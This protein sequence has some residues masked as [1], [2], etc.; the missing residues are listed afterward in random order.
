MKKKVDI[1][2]VLMIAAMLTAGPLMWIT[3]Q[4]EI[5]NNTAYFWEKPYGDF[6]TLVVNMKWLGLAMLEGS[7][8]CESAGTFFVRRRRYLRSDNQI[9]GGIRE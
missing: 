9:Q 6:E 5:H 2:M 8:L 4:L 7:L 3:A 1:G